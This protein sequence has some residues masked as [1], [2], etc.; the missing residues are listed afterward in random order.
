MAANDPPSWRGGAARL[1]RIFEH[2]HVPMVIVDASRRYVEVN[3][4]ARLA[5]GRSL[6]EMRTSTFGD[7]TPSHLAR[8]ADRTWARLLDTGR[9]AGRHQLATRDGS[10]H[11]I[12]IVYCGIAEVMPGLQLIAFAPAD[13]L[14]GELNATGDDRPGP[15]VSL[16]PRE[17]EV[18]ALAADGYSG[19]ELAQALLLR[20]STINA[21]FKNVYKK[22]DVRT[23]AAAVAE[24]IRLGLID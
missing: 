11:D 13:W 1:K 20:P 21:H 5:F 10:H 6:D 12:D 4:R 23:R 2:S 15:S 18:L 19:P 24:A 14:E 16:T 7:F 17:I 9:V 3:R 8:D 22:L